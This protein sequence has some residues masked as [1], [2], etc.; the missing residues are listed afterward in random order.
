MT[1]GPPPGPVAEADAD[2]VVDTGVGRGTA[3]D[4]TAER[5]RALA[6][7]LAGC[8]LLMSVAYLPRVADIFG[9]PRRPIALAVAGVGLVLL[10]RRTARREP[11]A[12][13]L[14]LLL[15]WSLVSSLLASTPLLS[16]VP[17]PSTENGWMYSA[18]Y[19]GWWAVGRSLGPLGR[20]WLV[21][22]LVIGGLANVALAIVQVVSAGG[23]GI[24]D[25]THG[26]AMGFLANPVHLGAFLAGVTAMVGV[27]GLRTDRRW[28]S[29]LPVVVATGAGINL[30]GTRVALVGVIVVMAYPLA[31]S[32]RLRSVA[33]AGAVV[34]GVALT[35]NALPQSGAGRVAEGGDA[36]GFTTRIESWKAGLDATVESPVFGWGPGRYAEATM[37]RNSPA[38]V[39][40]SDPYKYYDNAH[41]IVVEQVV[42]TGVVGLGLLGAFV[43]LNARRARGP[44]AY[45][46]SGLC[47]AWIVEP[48]TVYGAPLALLALG[49]AW[50]HPDPA[51]D[52]PPPSR[53]WS[54]A[55]LVAGVVGLAA[56]A[57]FVIADINLQ[58]ASTFAYDD[59]ALDGARRAGDLFSWDPFV[60]DSEAG[61]LTWRAVA[62]PTDAKVAAALEA[63]ARVVDLDRSF[64]PAWNQLAFTRGFFARDDEAMLRQTR[65]DYL[66]ALERMPWSAAALD[67]LHRT[68]LRLDDPEDA[69]RWAGQ[70]CEI[71]L[72]P[73]AADATSSEP[74]ST[75]NTDVDGPRTDGGD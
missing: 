41:N 27:I 43:I 38:Q 67:G 63:R 2:A 55:A 17:G 20:R 33:V 62:D 9:T 26:R 58:R 61:V 49:A 1:P 50:P 75:G 54:A 74:T 3:E 71:D 72:C 68:A 16:L 35:W 57:P 52:A 18:I 19:A 37:P 53:R 56:S 23:V 73:S 30:S 14:S 4:P 31:T 69:A 70:L 32:P 42:T 7:G 28:W 15:G 24:L 46:A 29:A 13:V 65:S 21:I 51:V 8:A 25:F 12:V 64:A 45:F 5:E 39:R 40:S 22:A 48:V 6:L 34:L 36:G 59:A 60:V 10:G 47:I 66:E 44:L 11:A